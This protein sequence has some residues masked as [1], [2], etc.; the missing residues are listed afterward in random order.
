MRKATPEQQPLASATEKRLRL[1]SYLSIALIAIAFMCFYL[2][3]YDMPSPTNPSLKAPLLL[4]IVLIAIYLLG[5]MVLLA[6]GY[7]SWVRTMRYY[8][9]REQQSLYKRLS[10]TNRLL[11]LLA[12]LM[13]IGYLCGSAD[14]ASAN[15][16][17]AASPFWQKAADMFIYII[18]LLL[19]TAIGAKLYGTIARYA[20]SKK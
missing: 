19:A 9:H 8:K 13:L 17:N 11:L 20:K 18:P 4:D 1:F 10:L 3:G 7:A 5:A 6:V 14:G 15:L 2:I 16:P 12:A